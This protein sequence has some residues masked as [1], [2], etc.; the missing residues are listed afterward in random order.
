M[1]VTVG[2]WSRSG[3][4]RQWQGLAGKPRKGTFP[5]VLLA[6]GRQ[7]RQLWRS[8]SAKTVLSVM[9][10]DAVIADTVRLEKRWWDLFRDCCSWRLLDS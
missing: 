9:E 4:S 3:L 10:G 5:H 2:D 8:P 7:R 1:L 6:G